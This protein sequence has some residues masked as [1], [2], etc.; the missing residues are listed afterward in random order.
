MTSPLVSTDWLAA[1]LTREDLRVLDCSVLMRT[2]A[3]G[4]YSFEPAKAE[5]AEAHVL[6]SAFVDVLAELSDRASPLPMMMPPP[7]S[8]ATVME[9]YGVGDGTHVVLYDRGNHAWAARVWWML[10]ACGFDSA[11]VLDGGWQKWHAERRPTSSA[12]A[13]Y[14]PGRFVPRPRPGAFVGRDAVLAA[15]DDPGVVLVNALSPEDHRGEAA[16]RRPRA[17]RIPGSCNVHCQSLIDPVTNTYRPREALREIFAAA[18]TLDGRRV[19]T[20]CGG[21]IAASSDAFALTLLGVRDVAVYDASLAEWSA[22]P[23]LPL[24]RG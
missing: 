21:G 23:T 8:F 9:G 19:V 7:A 3:D 15:L 14:R 6:G 11:S 13:Q 22:D 20:Y 18:G 5:Y 1:N 2:A 16:T 10:R 17:G 12:A 24:E 4:S